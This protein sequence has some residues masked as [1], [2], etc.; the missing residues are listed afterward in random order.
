MKKSFSILCLASYV[1]LLGATTTEV[2]ASTADEITPSTNKLANEKIVSD[3]GRVDLSTKNNSSVSER[4][5]KE[6]RDLAYN[7]TYNHFSNNEITASELLPSKNNW[8]NLDP[9]SVSDTPFAKVNNDMILKNDETLAAHGA[10][11]FNN[12][13]IAQTIS[14]ASFTYTQKDSVTTSTTHSTGISTTTSAEMKFPFVSGSMSMTVKYDF[15][16]TKAVESSVTKEWAVPS[17][18]INVPAG[19][20]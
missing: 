2:F 14:T 9:W 10:D 19:H 5:K 17:Q 1:M 15:N 7:L 11:L 13:G 6:L 12:T 16:S 18:H 8:S 4:V 3:N 20:K